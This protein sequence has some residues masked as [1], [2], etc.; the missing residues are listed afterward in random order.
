MPRRGVFLPGEQ[1]YEVIAEDMDGDDQN[2]INI[3]K[4]HGSK[5]I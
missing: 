2:E 1:I 4:A 5:P 3:Q